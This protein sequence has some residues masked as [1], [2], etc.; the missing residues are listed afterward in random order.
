MLGL[1]IGCAR[2]H[3]HKFDPIPQ[4]EYYAL[5][6]IFQSTKTLDGRLSGVFSGMH[7]TLLPETAS[8]IAAR[9][10]GLREWE[11]DYDRM[12][13][14][15]RLA[16]QRRDDLAAELEAAESGDSDSESMQ[17]LKG[18]SADAAKEATRLEQHADQLRVLRP[19]RHRR[20]RWLWP[21]VRFRPMHPSIS[22]AIPITAGSG[23]ARPP[24]SGAASG[25]AKIANRRLIG[26]GFQRAADAWNWPNG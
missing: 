24:F 8:E 5:A 20:W 23:F 21:T 9:A 17:D 12:L 22:G 15:L 18:K 26:Y 3:D 6:G 4:R 13:E 25:T 2:C 7:R 16:R 19:S 1:T 14:Q 10:D 11:R